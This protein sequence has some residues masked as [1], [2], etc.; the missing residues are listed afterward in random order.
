MERSVAARVSGMPFLTGLTYAFQSGPRVVMVMPLCA[1][2]TLQVQLDERATPAGG[3]PV[4]EVAW[5]GAQM[6]IALG[7][8]H[9]LRVLH[10]DVKPAN[11]LLRGNGYAALSDFGLAASLDQ[12]GRPTNRAGTR[13]YWAPE[14]D[15]KLEQSE[16]ADWWSLGVCLKYAATGVHPFKHLEAPQQED[17]GTDAA[18]A[19]EAAPDAS[20][21]HAATNTPSEL[22]AFLDAMLTE[23]PTKRLG[24]DGADSVLAQPLIA[25]RLDLALLRRG[26]LPAPWLPDARLVYAKDVVERHKREEPG[27][28]GS[29][30]ANVDEYEWAFCCSAETYAVELCELV[31]KTSTELLLLADEE[32]LPIGDAPPR[33]SR[34][35]HHLYRRRER[36]ECYG[37]CRRASKVMLC[38]FVFAFVVL[39]FVVRVMEIMA[40]DEEELEAMNVTVWY[41]YT[42]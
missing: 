33:A 18:L 19:A 21:A 14:V 42:S 3:L 11:I 13:S 12:G 20:R 34:W 8:L 29:V 16:A 2:G 35:R 41:P 26:L 39:Y 7:T 37:R 6:A 36:R 31:R 23:D 32:T 30:D 15:Q 38:C 1:G 4:H 17:G 9:G 24:A 40:L 22:T 5:I 10:R 28:Q 27:E 25:G